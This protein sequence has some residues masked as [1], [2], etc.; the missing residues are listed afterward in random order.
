MELIWYMKSNV[1][2]I[3][4]VA[5]QLVWRML[6]DQS[7]FV[8]SVSFFISPSLSPSLS[9]SL[10]LSLS[11]THTHTHTHTHIYIYIYIYI[12]T[13][14]WGWRIHRLHRWRVIRPQK[15]SVLDRTLNNLM[16][17]LWGLLSSPSLPSILSQL[18]F[19]VVVPDEVLSIGQR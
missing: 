8:R 15:M 16:L 9:L 1:K 19:G 7:E 11:H 3:A 14:G 13:V 6:S 12:C 2:C 4:T 5:Y 10:S 17:Q 18:W